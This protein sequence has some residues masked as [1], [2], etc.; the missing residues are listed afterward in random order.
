MSSGN[1][2]MHGN[3]YFENLTG[4]GVY[5]TGI[6]RRILIFPCIERPNPKLPQILIDNCIPIIRW[7]LSST[8]R[9]DF[10]LNRVE[11]I[12]KVLEGRERD[13]LRAFVFGRLSCSEESEVFLGAS[14]EPKEDTL[15][16][17]YHL[18]CRDEE[19]EKADKHK[20]GER[21]VSLLQSLQVPVEVRRRNKGLD[22][23]TTINF[24]NESEEVGPLS[25]EVFPESKV[26]A[27]VKES[28]GED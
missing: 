16:H 14:S 21:I 25:I 23:F 10:L 11:A 9:G 19:F 17:A 18:F 26:V 7:S 22:P 5:L 2:V 1:V 28:L 20:F 8:L 4:N 27:M 24:Q 15:F 6:S 3:N 13:S 12:N